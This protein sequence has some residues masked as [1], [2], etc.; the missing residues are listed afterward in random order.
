MSLA[1]GH[2]D[3]ERDRDGR[4]RCRPCRNAQNR[5]S[6]LR[7]KKP[8]PHNIIERLLADGGLHVHWVRVEKRYRWLIA[9]RRSALC[10][11]ESRCFRVRITKIAA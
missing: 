9:Y 5:Q 11:D 3:Q 8:H 10:A 6:H 4:W 2:A 7:R 1:C